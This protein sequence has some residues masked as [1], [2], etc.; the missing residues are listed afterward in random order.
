MV[1]VMVWELTS[2]ALDCDSIDPKGGIIATLP[3]PFPAPPPRPPFMGRRRRLAMAINSC[4]RR[5]SSNTAAS[6]AALAAAASAAIAFLVAATAAAT[7]S[8][9]QRSSWSILEGA[10]LQKQCLWFQ[11]RIRRI[12]DK[13]MSKDGLSRISSS[14]KIGIWSSSKDRTVAAAAMASAATAAAAVSLGVFGRPLPPLGRTPEGVRWVLI[15]EA[16][17]EAEV[18]EVAA[19]LSFSFPP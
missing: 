8:S 16:E 11:I 10:Q 5:L 9:A 12:A 17:A 1:L 18:E 7:A 4:W 3:P 2:A 19:K 15:G 6:A 14:M 13:A